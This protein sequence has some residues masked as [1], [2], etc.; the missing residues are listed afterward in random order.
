[1]SF[2]VE[3]VARDKA[4]ALLLLKITYEHSLPTSV[5]GF[6]TAAIENLAPA[7]ESSPRVLKVKA[8]GHLCDGPGWYSDSTATIEVM[9]YWIAR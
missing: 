8:V 6:V 1:M 9:P 3:F 5:R 7:E 4:H 2:H